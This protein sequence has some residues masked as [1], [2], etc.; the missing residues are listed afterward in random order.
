MA[1]DLNDIAVHEGLSEQIIDVHDA[2]GK[3]REGRAKRA[4][5]AGRLSGREE[6]RVALENI[7]CGPTLRAPLYVCAR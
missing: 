5:A 4:F 7:P 3:Q 6:A 1:S 2:S